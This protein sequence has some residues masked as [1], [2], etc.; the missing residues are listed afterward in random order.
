MIEPVATRKVNQR[1]IPEGM[2][3]NE[4]AVV[5]QWKKIREN[6]KMVKGICAKGSNVHVLGMILQNKQGKLSPKIEKDSRH[7]QNSIP[8]VLG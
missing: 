2:E 6:T 3:R 1:M 8:A 5:T 4:T 7:D